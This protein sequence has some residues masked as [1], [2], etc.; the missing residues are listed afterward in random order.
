M[1]Q[2]IHE[3]P[4]ALAAALS[5]TVENIGMKIGKMDVLSTD[6]AAR[7]D[8]RVVEVEIRLDDP[9]PVVSLT[10]LRVEVFIGP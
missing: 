7:T 1:L 3:P 4:P 9:T 2:E 8:A 6:P 5:G 10:N